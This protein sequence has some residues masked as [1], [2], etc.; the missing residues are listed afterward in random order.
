[1]AVDNRSNNKMRFAELQLSLRIWNFFL[2]LRHTVPLVTVYN[3][4]YFSLSL[5]CVKKP[6]S[7]D[8]PA[9]SCTWSGTRTASCRRRWRW[10]PCATRSQERA[11]SPGWDPPSLGWIWSC[12]VLKPGK[13]KIS[14]NKCKCFL[15]TSPVKPLYPKFLFWAFSDW[16]YSEHRTQNHYFQKPS[17]STKRAGLKPDLVE[18]SLINIRWK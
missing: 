6:V 3:T 2:F 15:L 17:S 9:G 14:T 5:F 1:M 18:C 10:W 7:V 13:K 11:S 8:A 16:R 12:G 4:R